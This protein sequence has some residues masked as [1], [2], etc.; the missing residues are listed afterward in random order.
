MQAETLAGLMGL[1]GAVVGAGVSTGAVIWQ[2]QKTAQDSERSYRLGLGES[3]ANEI[4]RMSFEVEDLL[5]LNGPPGEN[6][7]ADLRQRC[8]GIE[9][10]S[11]KFTDGPVRGFMTRANAELFVLCA[12]NDVPRMGEVSQL[13]IDIRHVMGFVLRRELLPDRYVRAR[14]DRLR[15]HA[16]P[17][18]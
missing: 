11:L 3:A 12:R 7:H 1:A 10:E 8:R 6:W 13:L 18:A 2:Q 17:P 4:I 9:K 5:E 14:L 15:P 16:E